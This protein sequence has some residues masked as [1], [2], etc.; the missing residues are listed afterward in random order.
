MHDLSVC[1]QNTS[2][3]PKV[4]QAADKHIVYKSTFA[5][6]VS[7]LSLTKAKMVILLENA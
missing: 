7:R 1:A 6:C 5:G 2:I 3:Y 4:K